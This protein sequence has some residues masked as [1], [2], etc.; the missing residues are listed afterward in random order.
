MGHR[1]LATFGAV[2]S[3]LSSHGIGQ[4]EVDA[5]ASRAEWVATL[6]ALLHEP[7]A[8]EPFERLGERLDRAGVT[9]IHVSPEVTVGYRSRLA[10]SPGRTTARFEGGQEFTLDPEQPFDGGAVARVGLRGGSQKVLYLI[11]GGGTFDSDYSQYDIR[12]M[13]RFQ[14]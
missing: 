8:E 1:E 4:L 3:A 5:E 10:G 12:A 6:T 11:D 9:H 7:A 14:F 2:G 13:V